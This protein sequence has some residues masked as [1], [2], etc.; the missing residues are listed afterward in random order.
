MA[1]KRGDG[2]Q[3]AEG[4]R[5]RN[6]YLKMTSLTE[7]RSRFLGRF[8]WSGFLD[9]ETVPV[10]DALGRVLAAAVPARLSAPTYHG[11]AMDGIAVRARETFGASETSPRELSV[12][13]Q[14]RF[15]NTG[16]PLPEGMDAVVMIE[17]VQIL[18][19]ATVRIEGPAFPW[20]HVRRVG[21]DIVATELLFVRGRKL[22][23]YDIGALIA[24]GVSTVSVLRRPRVLIVPTGAELIAPEDVDLQDLTPGR[25]IDFN[26]TMLGKAA[27]ELGAD[28]VRHATMADD[29][30]RL[31]EL[32]RGACD[33]AY[34]LVLIL[35]GSSAGSK[36]F[37]RAAV[38][39][40]GDVLVHGVTMMPGK[41]TVL[42]VCADRPVIGVPGYP[43]SAILCFE[44][45]VAPA[46][47]AMQGQP[48]P[49][50][51]LI[52]ARPT[53]TIASKLGMEEFIRVRLGRVADRVVATPLP[54]GSGTV[55]SLVRADGMIRVPTELEGI[56]AGDAVDVELL[57]PREEIEGNI[58]AVGSHDLLMELL[59]D[60][61]RGRPGGFSLSS[62]HIG[63]LGG[64][65]ALRDGGCH[66]AP[67]HLLDPKDGSYNRSFVARYCKKMQLRQLHLAQ[68][69]QGLMVPRGNPKGVVGLADLS[70][71][72]LLFVNRQGGSGTRVLLDHQLRLLGLDAADIAGYGV[73]ETTHM[74]VAVAVASGAADV[75]L[76]VRSAARA[77]GVDFVPVAME[78][79]DLLIPEAFWEHPG[80]AAL[81]EVIASDEFK[82]AMRSL[83]GYDGGRTGDVTR[84]G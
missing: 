60:L 81:R 6:V 82:A 7:A 33:G 18:D 69:E 48:E 21:E 37:T 78:D 2:G 25:I 17:R 23:P 19:D 58:I 66:L 49:R 72:D 51:E 32:V 1:L 43:V 22:G 44:Q 74:G 34:D 63:S 12:P 31:T 38:Q 26:S 20:Q 40:A 29:L 84:L 70:R 8:D 77:L 16:E 61:L 15:V 24:A 59:A 46:L 79:Y 11:A 54:R 13:G 4:G 14:A 27:E 39:D 65:R 35:G 73:E 28:F 47:A 30:P 80:I 53:R 9:A 52:Q 62:S 64:L 10:S 68:R 50:R 57:R 41:P 36:D 42:G 3:C 45:F 55:S 5:H 56:A 83:G 76:G 75:G 71:D 67:S